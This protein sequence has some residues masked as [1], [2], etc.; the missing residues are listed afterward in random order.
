MLFR[1]TSTGPAAPSA[2]LTPGDTK[3]GTVTQHE[4]DREREAVSS[5]RR[6]PQC[7]PLPDVSAQLALQRQQ[8]S[9]KSGGRAFTQGAT[10]RSLGKGKS[11]SRGG[12]CREHPARQQPPWRTGVPAAAPALAHAARHHSLGSLSSQEGKN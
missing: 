2:A 11:A 4:G 10:T 7:G 9:T 1:S 8:T 5:G 6:G 12:S 3:R